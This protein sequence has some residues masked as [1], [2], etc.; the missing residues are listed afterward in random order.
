MVV[1]GGVSGMS[2]AMALGNMGYEVDLIEKQDRLGGLLNN[3][4]IVLPA[5]EP[6]STLLNDLSSRLEQNSNVTIHTTMWQPLLAT[7]RTNR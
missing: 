1:G 4:N 5:N 6:P 7:T 3:H 2:A